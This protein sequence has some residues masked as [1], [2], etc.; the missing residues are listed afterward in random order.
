MNNK[1]LYT[2]L[3]A[4]MS[5]NQLNVSAQN[6]ETEEIL[7][8]DEVKMEFGSLE[9]EGPV[10]IMNYALTMGTHLNS[11]VVDVAMNVNGRRYMRVP[12]SDMSGDFGQITSSGLKTIRYNVDAIKEKI[13]G[14]DVSFTL[15]VRKKQY[16]KEFALDNIIVVSYCIPVCF[17]LMYG[18]V[19]QKV[20]GYFKYGIDPT[21]WLGTPFYQK[22]AGGPLFKA[23]E[24]CYPYVGIAPIVWWYDGATMLEVGSVFCFGKF[25]LNASL[26]GYIPWW[27]NEAFPLTLTLGCGVKF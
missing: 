18:F 20:G 15:Q 2:C 8:D 5:L 9:R 16:K 25:A 24:W 22:F 26:Q 3:L 10:I 11:C 19:R 23:K 14:K 4:I 21:W 7:R 1:F 12:T 27:D 13:A 17:D 6:M